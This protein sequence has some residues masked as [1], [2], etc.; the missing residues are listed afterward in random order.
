MPDILRTCLP[1]PLQNAIERLALP[2]VEDVRLHRDRVA[3]LTYKGNSY[4]LGI[5]PCE[6][7]IQEILQRM[8]GGS[9]YAYEESIRQG[10]LPLSGG[11]RV[12]V[13]GSAACRDGRVIGVSNVTGLMIRIPNTVSVCATPILEHFLSSNHLG[14]ILIYAPPG[15]GK[16][17]LLRAVAKA[18]SAP[19]LSRHTV[20]VDS[21]GELC[22]GL[23]GQD[24]SL[25]ILIGYPKEL[26][27]EIA[28]RTM[29]AQLILCDELGSEEDARAV[30]YSANCGV[31]LIATAHASSVT[32]LLRRP[33]F[34][35]LHQAGVFSAYAGIERTQGGTFRYF[36]SSHQEAS[37]LCLKHSAC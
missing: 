10:F 4:S 6:H 9:L 25:D 15:V 7:D 37:A 14:G 22:Y 28:T 20:V 21:R 27:I 1:L 8:C 5:I 23:S 36:F 19:P 35:K 3:T 16:T 18:A 31:P 30:L 13:C 24:L 2:S 32:E 26:G 29:G 33:V 11:I 34:A 17:T 12:G